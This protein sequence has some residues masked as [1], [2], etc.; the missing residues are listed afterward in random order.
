M[1]VLVGNDTRLL[2]QGLTG[3][4]GTFHTRQS[5]SYGTTVVA[6]VTPG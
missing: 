5:V 4:E 6:G 2:V 1:A 3:K